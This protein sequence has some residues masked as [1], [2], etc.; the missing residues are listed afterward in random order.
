MPR[1]VTAGAAR[2]FSLCV[3]QSDFSVAVELDR[4]VVE[5][6]GEH[7]AYTAEKLARA[8]GDLI[9]RGLGVSID[10]RQA[11]FIDSSVIGVLLAASRRAGDEGRDFDLLL[12][13]ETGWP[14]RRLLE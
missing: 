2:A 12:G 9:D 6:R 5:L 3:E 8:V 14:V 4:A 11:A 13:A 1:T 7:E 10:L